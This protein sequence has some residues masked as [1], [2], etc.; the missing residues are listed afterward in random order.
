M[1]PTTTIV[2]PVRNAWE[3]EIKAG[4]YPESDD[5]WVDFDENVKYEE[6]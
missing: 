3:V 1:V 2:D 5:Q 4:K 6:M